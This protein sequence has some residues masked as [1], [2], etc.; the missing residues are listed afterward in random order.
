MSRYG[1]NIGRKKRNNLH[2]ARVAD[3][4]SGQRQHSARNVF[5]FDN[6]LP[7]G[8]PCGIFSYQQINEQ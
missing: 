6:V 5:V 1:Q 4:V 2:F 8:N 3:G 7:S